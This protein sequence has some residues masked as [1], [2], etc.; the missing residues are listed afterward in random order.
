MSSSCQPTAITEK[1]S[2]SASPTLM[3]L[4]APIANSGAAR[5]W[6]V[7]SHRVAIQL[8]I[9]SPTGTVSASANTIAKVSKLNPIGAVYMF[10]IH[11]S[12]PKMAI[13]SMQSIAAR[14]LNRGF[15]AKVGRTS[16]ITPDAKTTT[17]M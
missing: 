9:S 2:S 7:P 16:E 12:G 14:W 15:R 11:A 6:S 5:G 10:C 4:I 13:A 3:A 17:I 1:A 8:K